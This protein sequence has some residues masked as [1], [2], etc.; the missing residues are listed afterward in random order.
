MQ[1]VI[2]AAGTGSRLRPLTEHIP[3]P[4]VP[5]SFRGGRVVTIIDKI[6]NQVKAAGIKDVFVVVNYKKEM[7][8]KYLGDGSAYGLHVTYVFQDKLDGNGG[9]LF[10][11]KGLATEDVLFTDCDNFV[12]DEKIF[13]K[14]RDLFDESRAD[15]VVGVNRVDDITRFAIFKTDK[16]GKIVDIFEK[17]TDR[18]EWGNLAK[19]GFAIIAGKVIKMDRDVCKTEKGEYA[20]TQ[21]FKHMLENG[22]K[23]APYI[24][25]AE[26]EDIGTWE[27]YGKILDKT[28]KE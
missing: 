18:K 27:S 15:A 12:D 10:R 19:T 26:F 11:C 13:L 21:L 9:A 6:I 24:V 25:E 2:L 22:M 16:T 17:P 14:M 8:Q 7:I 23:L 28:S 4:L 3:K 5:V 20:T 1:A